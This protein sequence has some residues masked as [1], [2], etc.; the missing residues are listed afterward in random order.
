VN[1]GAPTGRHPT[2][3]ISMS[4]VKIVTLV[5]ESKKGWQEAA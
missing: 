5:G 1:P 3:R 2:R 4:V